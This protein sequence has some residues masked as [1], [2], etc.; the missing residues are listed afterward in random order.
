MAA[1]ISPSVPNYQ[2]AASTP[3]EP[4]T[5]ITS[6]L[7]K[8]DL[9]AIFEQIGKY[10]CQVSTLNGTCSGTLLSGA[11][12]VVPFHAIALSI[13]LSDGRK[14]YRVHPVTVYCRGTTYTAYY[15]YPTN[16]NVAQHYDACVFRIADEDFEPILPPT[17]MLEAPIIG[18]EIYFAGYP[19]AQEVPSFHR[20]IVSSIHESDEPDG[21]ICFNIDASIMPGNS[22][23]PVFLKRAEQL[24]LSGIIFAGLG[25]IDPQFAMEKKRIVKSLSSGGVRLSGGVDIGQTIAILI[26]VIFDNFSTGIGKVLNLKHVVELKSLDKPPQEYPPPF[27]LDSFPLVKTEKLVGMLSKDLEYFEWWHRTVKPKPS[28]SMRII[29]KKYGA[30]DQITKEDEETLWSYYVK[31]IQS[32]PKRGYSGYEATEETKL[33]NLYDKVL[34]AKRKGMKQN[35]NTWINLLHTKYSHPDLQSQ[36]HQEMMLELYTHLETEPPPTVTSEPEAPQQ[37]ESISL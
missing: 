26:N 37:T 10:V 23:G 27:Y 4:S 9:P 18:E 32:D 12:V 22:G 6:G 30:A 24:F 17:T 35:R 16:L 25:Q 8:L 19:L 15:A 13:I 5:T 14:S 2:A 1:N 7:D 20:G 36:I 29:G 34:S 21:T 33:K 11:D 28:L 3:A 31:Y